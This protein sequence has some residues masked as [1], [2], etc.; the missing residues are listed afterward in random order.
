V[1][2]TV[3]AEGRLYSF[4]DDATDDQISEALTQF[5]EASFGESL[6][7]VPGRV[8]PAAKE[9][10]I[11]FQRMLVEPGLQSMQEGGMAEQ[12]AKYPE[13][14]AGQEYLKQQNEAAGLK[15]LAEQAAAETA[16]A[17]P[18]G[19]EGFWGGVV[20]SIAESAPSTI[21]GLGVAALTKSP[22]LGLAVGLGGGG[23]MQAGATYGEAERLTGDARAAGRAAGFAGVTE[24]ALEMLPMKVMMRTGPKLLQ[25]AAEVMGAE[26]LQ[27]FITQAIQTTDA[28]YSYDPSL[29]WEDVLV[30]SLQAGLAGALG[31]TIYAPLGHLTAK[32]RAAQRVYDSIPP[33]VKNAL[34]ER[35]AAR[36]LRRMGQPATV[37]Q[38]PVEQV[39]QGQAVAETVSEQR[40]R[41]IADQQLGAERSLDEILATIPVDET[42]ATPTEL[43][44]Q[45]KQIEETPEVATPSMAPIVDQL[46][47]AQQ[48]VQDAYHPTQ[49]KKVGENPNDGVDPLKQ[50]I[51][52]SS[53]PEMVNRPVGSVEFTPGTHV[54]G[55]LGDTFGRSPL[56]MTALVDV[57]EA[58]RKV[59]MPDRA[60]FI[61]TQ[62]LGRGVNGVHINLGP[63]AFYIVPKELPGFERQT[64]RNPDGSFRINFNSNATFS[65]LLQWQNTAMHEF[66]HAFLVESLFQNLTDPMER[67]QAH[68]M[69]HQLGP[70]ILS[71]MSPEAG[72][73]VL[74]YQ[75]RYARLMG[76]QMT[77]A[78]F[79]N[80]W[81]AP[82]KAMQQTLASREI[83]EQLI[84]E[85]YDTKSAK[86]EGARRATEAMPALQYLMMMAKMAQGSAST[87]EQNREW[88][89][90]HIA[91][92]NEY[93]SEQLARYAFLRNVPETAPRSQGFWRSAVE[94]FRR[95]YVM[96]KTD[97]VQVTMPVWDK[98]TKSYL[99]MG[100]PVKDTQGNPLVVKLKPGVKFEE[101]LT[102]YLAAKSPGFV[103][104][105][106]L[107]PAQAKP[108]KGKPVVA[109]PV[110]TKEEQLAAALQESATREE[111]QGERN[112]K[113]AIAQ[114]KA[115]DPTFGPKHRDFKMLVDWINSGYW[116]DVAAY[117]GEKIGK[118][119]HFDLSTEERDRLA[120]L[121][122]GYV[123]HAGA[124]E[125]K[126]LGYQASPTLTEEDALRPEVRAYATRLWAEQGTKS[127]FFKG[128][129]GDWEADPQGSSKVRSGM[130]F[131][132]EAQVGSISVLSSG[133]V[134]LQ[135]F[136][137]TRAD[138]EM[139]KKSEDIGFH[140]GSLRAAHNRLA[141]TQF[142][143]LA[144]AQD[145]FETQGKVLKKA[146]VSTAGQAFTVDPITLK[147]VYL[148]EATD[149]LKA[150]IIPAFL[151]LRNPLWVGVEEA[152]M[153]QSPAGM[154]KF[155]E[156]RGVITPQESSTLYDQVTIVIDYVLG[157]PSPVNNYEIFV[158][159]RQFLEQRGHDGL[160]YL[161]LVEGDISW[162]AFRPEQVKSSKSMTY[163]DSPKMHLDVNTDPDFEQATADGSAKISV[164][165]AWK[166]GGIARKALR[167]FDKIADHTLQLQQKAWMH[168]EVPGLSSFT[169]DLMSYTRHAA[170]LHK[171]AQNFL[172]AMGKLPKEHAARL[173]RALAE[174]FVGGEWMV[175]WQPRQGA[176]RFAGLEQRTAIPTEQTKLFLERLGITD[177]TDAG[178][179]TAKLFVEAVQLF[180][181]Y[182]FHTAH[183]LA[184]RIPARFSKYEAQVLE[185]NALNRQMAELRSVPFL[186]QA[187]F[188][189]YVALVYAMVPDQEG[190]LVRTLVRKEAFE[191]REEYEKRV[192]ELV[193]KHGVGNV[194]FQEVPDRVAVLMNLPLEFFEDAVR[195][196]VLSEEDAEKLR[197]LMLP[198]KK[199][200]LLARFKESYSV[201]GGSKNLQRVIASF[202]WH[203]ANAIAKFRYNWMLQQDLNDIRSQ[204]N[205]FEKLAGIT[206]EQ[207]AQKTEI[208]RLLEFARETKDYV[209]SPSHELHVLRAIVSTGFL[210]FNVKTALL[211]LNGM[212]TTWVD[213]TT[214]LGVARGTAE[215]VKAMAALR[216]AWLNPEKIM[217]ARLEV[218]RAEAAG[219]QPSEAQLRAVEE[220]EAL[221][222][223]IREGVVDQSYAYYLASQANAGGTSRMYERMPGAVG[224]AMQGVKEAFMHYGMMPFAWTENMA[225]MTTFL[226]QYRM[227]REMGESVNE[228]F[229]NAAQ[230][231][232]LLQN[233][234]T[235]VNRPKLLRGN[236]SILF[237]FAQWTQHMAWHAWGGYERGLRA[238]IKF[239]NEEN[240]ELGGKQIPLPKLY[241]S[242]TLRIN[243]LMLLLAGL[244][245]L[246][247]AENLFDL[248]DILWR[249]MFGKTARQDA[250]EFVKETL[251]VDP[252]LVMHGL[253]HGKVLPG[254]DISRSIGL[255]RIIPGTDKLFSS[256]KPLQDLGAFVLD[257]MGPLGGFVKAVWT[258][259]YGVPNEGMAPRELASRMP[260]AAGSAATAYRWAAEGGVRGPGEGVIYKPTP[261]EI[262]MRGLG[263]QPVG[264][265]VEREIRFEQ[266]VTREYWMAQQRQIT[267]AYFKARIYDDREG[268][269]DVKKMI[270]RYNSRVPDA[271]LKITPKVLRDSFEARRRTMQQETAAQPGQRKYRNTYREVEES[272]RAPKE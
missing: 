71:K 231:T 148:G 37:P 87:P 185:Y 259:M 58:F 228:S 10:A 69:A 174:H 264:P 223:A 205:A 91:S 234:Y 152:Y 25:R 32:Q 194:E 249:K 258:G 200:K 84:R 138:Y 108:K 133:S 146:T 178:R 230:Q 75:E 54:V 166:D 31:G 224:T 226:L 14:P 193:R 267:E 72:A 245:G 57:I 143:T 110:L 21:A 48:R 235:T 105:L 33:S 219:T 140:F 189:N 158:P 45:A 202:T 176:S 171:Q 135:V 24:G 62:S 167:W 86:A 85:G 100:A 126:I 157:G 111:L 43:H 61:G 4:P 114:I 254:Y 132:R 70:E 77:L 156:T 271:R 26:A 192:P 46:R 109:E 151:N 102:G 213:A 211:N 60:V 237:I 29:S 270:E 261:T 262:L 244:E 215:T 119:V 207:V 19:Q 182:Y 266:F 248:L 155:L 81:A 232:S 41:E 104:Q 125:R 222:R 201:Q 169:T 63:Q 183:A 118:D 39:L 129:F 239:A 272:F 11:N 16:A 180:D 78:E 221:M 210:A 88:V 196:M 7:S 76:G 173:E 121:G 74:E 188:G 268:Q 34:E 263:F 68:L 113:W 163:S 40:A 137:G 149:S 159:I 145:W 127:P 191:S 209:M 52:I 28:K 134:P 15:P 122:V 153:W 142:Q 252:A 217:Q 246:P 243:L 36:E 89:Q 247:G 154:I 101:W 59:V 116:D 198:G 13:S 257:W 2:K 6:A 199:D 5:R 238:Q 206:P 1:P 117:I 181:D 73:V 251:E 123:E 187:W 218:Q 3:S 106:E 241:Q 256:G 179:T 229:L 79:R 47:D 197:N 172:Q 260:G 95:M 9:A 220:S 144:A 50:S 168:P 233:D 99:P 67:N 255:G 120:E 184:G 17:R 204:I 27:E 216:S 38:T 214:R 44:Q 83:T 164:L 98:Q 136:H 65:R 96:L 139:F 131:P 49:P 35:D 93:M 8:V 66:G 103:S 150:N 161:N 240:A 56:A 147:L 253:G 227:H 128:W 186:P 64:S 82:A 208:E 250:R 90:Q 124:T 107:K 162:V 20:G 212:M 23:A 141:Q 94:A 51:A 115:V 30:S 42:P 22:A 203:Q 97:G 55:T 18:A 177:E 53:V 242:Y 170:P 236:K 80:E 190:E 12:A 265:S 130:L 225:R 112:K 269:A 160:V 165:R 92:I 175:D 195:E